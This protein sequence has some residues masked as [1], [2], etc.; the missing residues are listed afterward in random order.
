MSRTA[1]AT[2]PQLRGLY[3]VTTVAAI[4]AQARLLDAHAPILVVSRREGETTAKLHLDNCGVLGELSADDHSEYAVHPLSALEAL[5]DGRRPCFC[6]GLLAADYTDVT[7]IGLLAGW[8]NTA[9]HLLAEDLALDTAPTRSFRATAECSRV[10]TLRAAALAWHPELSA[11]HMHLH[12]IVLHARNALLQR[13]ETLV[14]RIG[15][16]EEVARMALAAASTFND[17]TST[18]GRRYQR[19]V[20]QW[21][22]T[23]AELGWEH[24]PAVTLT[25][26]R[27][28]QNA[29]P[30]LAAKIWVAVDPRYRGSAETLRYV[31]HTADTKEARDGKIVA[32]I[33]L[34]LALRADVAE[35]DVIGRDR[36][37]TVDEAVH[38]YTSI[39]NTATR[40]AV[41]DALAATRA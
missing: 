20:E 1:T 24:A 3:G 34:T 33:P 21:G 16:Q 5:W 40:A 10:S 15:Y 13:A 39:A 36:G 27:D 18:Q 26:D 38:S 4:L 32:R 29:D 23:P 14:G 12:A 8:I 30:Y 37:H 9:R 28:I 41:L 7:G 19:L 22:F 25:P 6:L 35:K 2:Q 31:D 11:P 17:P